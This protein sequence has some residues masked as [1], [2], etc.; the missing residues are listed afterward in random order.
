MPHLNEVQLH[1]QMAAGCKNQKL[2]RLVSVAAADV[3]FTQNT[4]RK[5]PNIVRYVA[6]PV[7]R[8]L[9]CVCC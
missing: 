8:M 9:T 5:G 3:M 7:K 4:I 2:L 1:N 6:R